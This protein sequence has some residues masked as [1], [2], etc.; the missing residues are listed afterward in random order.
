MA[1]LLRV[2]TTDNSRT[3]RRGAETRRSAAAPPVRRRGVKR[4]GCGL[5]ATGRLR[6]V[7]SGSLCNGPLAETGAGVCSSGRKGGRFFFQVF[8]IFLCLQ[9]TRR[10]GCAPSARCVRGRARSRKYRRGRVFSCRRERLWRVQ[11]SSAFAA[12]PTFTHARIT[13]SCAPS[14]ADKKNP[15]PA[16]I[17]RDSGTRA[18][19]TECDSAAL[20]RACVRACVFPQGV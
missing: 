19:I 9:R 20:E 16:D 3:C 14:V 18:K 10:G 6:S 17:F 15:D 8:V 13:S 11:H 5:P 2:L 7:C 12:A 4:R 1:K